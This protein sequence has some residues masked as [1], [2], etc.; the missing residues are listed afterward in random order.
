MEL[1]ESVVREIIRRQ[2]EQDKEEEQIKLE[3]PSRL[4]AGPRPPY[5]GS[6]IYYLLCGRV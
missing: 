5:E 1:D 2:E 4:L 3:C 6:S